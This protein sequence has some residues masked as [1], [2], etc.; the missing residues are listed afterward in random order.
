MNALIR[1][2]FACLLALSLAQA[3]GITSADT[4]P[5]P[6]N[7]LFLLADDMQ[8]DAIGALGH[9]VVKTPS[10]DRLVREGF[11]FRQCYIMGS[12]VPA[13]CIPSRAMLWSGRNLWR[14]RNDLANLT[15]LPELLRKHGY[16]T[17][18]TGKWHNGRPSLARS[19]TQ[20][21]AIFFGGMSDHFKVPVFDFDPT[22]KY[23]Q[24]A[25]YLA[26]QFSTE[27]FAEAAR[28]FLETYRGHR[29]FFMFV[30]FTAPH[31]PRTPPGKYATM[32]KPDEIPLPANFLPEHPFDNGELKVRDELL[33]PFPRTAE[34][35]RQ[36]LADYFGMITHMDAEVGRILAALRESP[37][38]NDTLVVFSSD[39]GLAVGQHGLL[40]KQN[41]YEHSIR[42]PLIITGPGIPPGQSDALVYLHDLFPTLCELLGIDPPV[43]IDAQSLV[44][45][46]RGT[47][48]AGRSHLIFAYRAEQRAIRSGPWKLIHYRVAGKETLQLFNLQDDP[49]ELRN[50]ADDPQHADLCRRLKSLLDEECRL[51][52][53]PE[54]RP[55]S[56]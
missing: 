51:Q 33:A 42:V 9:P 14:T 46:I 10:L 30:S 13:V 40:G 25:Q 43:N 21:K 37:Y 17:F 22:G 24:T 32:Y 44:P 55:A 26:K 5:A 27:L 38:A 2:G 35:I 36:H 12:T 11:C 6:R 52:G 15:T 3:A 29:P 8:A 50:L 4:R 16:E 18:I 20:G 7:V 39:N 23:P 41:L 48:S 56:D 49:W 1:R 19:F 28:G 31:D 34:V 47:S 45:I 53:D 54:A